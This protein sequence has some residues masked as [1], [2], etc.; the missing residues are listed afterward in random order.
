V[1]TRLLLLLGQFTGPEAECVARLE[2]WSSAGVLGNVAWL[3]IPSSMS[4]RPSVIYSEAGAQRNFDLF[5]LLTSRMWTEV[6]IVALRQGDLTAMEESRFERERELLELIDEAFKAHAELHLTSFTVSMGSSVGLVQSAFSTSW[7]MHLLQEPIVRTDQFVAAQPL[8]DEYRHLLV[9]FLALTAGG[10]L[11]WQTATLLGTL[12]DPVAGDSRPLR[13]GRAYVRVLT[14]GRLTDEILAGAFPASGPWSVPPDLPN[15]QAVPPSSVIPTATVSD[16][17]QSAGFVFRRFT[18]TS[19]PRPQQMGLLA[20][21][22]LFAQEFFK[23]LRGIPYQLVLTVKQEVADL[24]TSVT[25]GSESSV[26]LSFDP[27]SSDLS[28]EDTVRVLKGLEIGA[29]ADPVSNPA[30]WET[31]QNVAFACVDGG[32]FPA[33]ITEPKTGSTRLVYTNPATIGPSPDDAVFRLSEFEKALFTIDDETASVGPIDIEG[34]KALQLRIAAARQAIEDSSAERVGSLGQLATAA[35]TRGGRRK[36]WWRRRR[37]KEKKAKIAVSVSP[38]PSPATPVPPPPPSSPAAPESTS[39]VSDD[40]AASTETTETVA[41]SATPAKV[42][43]PPV[44]AEPPKK[45]A[46][47]MRHRPTHP[48]FVATEYVALASFYQGDKAAIAAEYSE[49]NAVV[50]AARASHAPVE[51]YWKLNKGCDHCGTAFDHGVAFLHE[52]SGELVHVGHICARKSFPMT[53]QA[54]FLKR[55]IIDIDRRFG[56]WLSGRSGSLLWRVGMSIVDG[57]IMARSELASALEYLGSVSA[58]QSAETAA[59]K[60]FGRWTRRGMLFFVLLLAASIASVVLTPL[61]LLLFVV[62]LTVY[63]T[64]LVTRLYFLARD[65]VRAKYRLQQVEGEI[66]RAMER[67]RHDA[68]EIVRLAS[69]R[70]QFEDWQAIIREIVHIPFGR[71]VGSTTGRSGITDVT[72]PPAMILGRS[73]PDN[74]QKMRLFMNARR[75]TI[76]AGWLHEIMDL[77]KADWRAE[78]EL[79]RMTGPADNIQPESDIAPSGSVVGKRPLSEENVHYPRT[80]FRNQVMTGELQRKVVDRKSVQVAEDLRRTDISQLL[81]PVEVTGLGGALNGLPVEE[82]LTGLFDPTRELTLYP[83]ELISNLYPDRQIYGPELLV[84]DREH[85]GN[86]GNQYQ[87]HPGVELT[88]AAWRLELSGPIHPLDML[89]GYVPSVITDTGVSDDDQRPPTESVV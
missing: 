9:L 51:G 66:E 1:T 54:D 33:G 44:A 79:V 61:P 56:E 85:I 52:P 74:A 45:T 89:R 40:D 47:L 55:R 73:E 82:F 83:P 11:V 24:M 7:K 41:D 18:P 84:P 67:A 16:L 28:T 26:V 65:I 19:K 8:W 30:A 2:Q 36:R 29:D 15:S 46:D 60:R 53:D 5:E 23:A 6:T 57:L 3:D 43:E 12:S 63:S 37:A 17:T 25:F 22:R 4:M 21:L 75:Q 27:A 86:V 13:V 80:E 87:V 58:V 35:G 76:H 72:R 48:K 38:A 39:D 32:R 77:M 88:V 69:V 62:I 81:G 59:H 34:A 20:G 70:E 14:A 49:S 68:V 50:E 42:P 10:G 64:G 31:L 78:Y 71:E